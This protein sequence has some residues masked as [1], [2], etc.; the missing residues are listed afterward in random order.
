M[1]LEIKLKKKNIIPGKKNRI[2]INGITYATDMNGNG[3]YKLISNKKDEN[4]GYI[5]N[6]DFY[7]NENKDDLEIL[8]D[9]ITKIIYNN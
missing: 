6:K 8:K 4:E 5:I 2:I 3:L 7:F 9:K 1:K